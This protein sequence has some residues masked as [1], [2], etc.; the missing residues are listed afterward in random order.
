[1]LNSDGEYIVYQGSDDLIIAMSFKFLKIS[2]KV[3]WSHLILLEYLL[4][5][6]MKMVK[7]LAIIK[8]IYSNYL[9]FII[10]IIEEIKKYLLKLK[11]SKINN[12][13]R[14]ESHILVLFY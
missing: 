13:L 8:E 10:L 6:N 7:L 12:Y 4:D 11:F 14:F 1:M 5:V 3:R 9:M 2:M